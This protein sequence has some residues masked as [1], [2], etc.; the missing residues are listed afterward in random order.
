MDSGSGTTGG[1]GPGR[2]PFWRTLEESCKGLGSVTSGLKINT[3]HTQG[4]GSVGQRARQG[5]TI[6]T[7]EWGR[8]KAVQD[9][10]GRESRLK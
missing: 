10:W 4:L 9:N 3:Q 5:K 8:G 1:G 6:G 7:R 2:P